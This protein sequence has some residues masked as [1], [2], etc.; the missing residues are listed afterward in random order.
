MTYEIPIMKYFFDL[1]NTRSDLRSKQLLKLPK[2]STSRYGTQALCF[3]VYCNFGFYYI[4]IWFCW[5]LLVELVELF[6]KP[7]LNKVNK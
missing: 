2:T 1:K 3:I 7:T 6:C 5:Y 4:L